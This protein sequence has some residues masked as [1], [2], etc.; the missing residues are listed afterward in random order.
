MSYH[1]CNGIYTLLS[2]G[3][4]VELHLFCVDADYCAS[5]YVTV[6]GETVASMDDL[7]DMSWIIPQAYAASRGEDSRIAYSEAVNMET[8]K[9]A[10]WHWHDMISFTLKD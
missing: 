4:T 2:E 7:N 1:L 10:W 6:D 9:R 5:D 3:Q 8:G